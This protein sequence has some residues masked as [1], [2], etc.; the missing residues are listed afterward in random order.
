MSET[1]RRAVPHIREFLADSLTPLG[2]YRRLAELS[3]HRF[4]LESV[5]GGERVSRF[6]FLGAGPREVYRLYPDRLEVER[7]G[8]RSRLPGLPLDALREVIHRIHSEPGPIPFTGGLVG[9][10]GYDLIRMVERLPNR[11]ADPFGL[12]IAMLARFDTLVIFDHAYQR[13]LAIANEIEGEVNMATA[14]RQLARIS[15][16]LTNEAGGGGV[17]MPE[18][19]P[20]RAAA[21]PSLD[22]PAFRKAVLAAKEHIAA[23]DIFQVV[24][25][26]RWTVPRRVDPLALYRAVRMVNPSPYMVL[27]ESPD[28]SLVGASP[29]MLVRKQG[30]HLENRPI[31]GTRPRGM[32]AEGDKRLAEDLLADAK[33]RAEHVML[34][35]LGRNDLGR[36]ATA[37]SVR[38]ASFME[39]ERYS[40]VMHMV[41]SVEAELEAGKDGLDALLACFPAGTVSG[42]PKIRAME[43]IDELEPE[44]RGPYAGAVGYLSYSG[45]LDTCIAIRTLVVEE[46]RTSVTAGAGIVA[47]SDP[48]A[49][50]KETENKAAALLAAVA[51]AEAL[52]GRRS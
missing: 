40:H 1:P 7:G 6:S 9:Y 4:L 24:L 36:V 19:S 39:I 45:D 43:I 33:E 27:F 22:G 20:G 8:K 13:V 15:K 52:E 23:G 51:L 35:D 42:A 17:A 11:P 3:P 50:E 12:P 44:A 49:E 41:S 16:L 21:T 34:V 38:V 32:D 5:T 18:Q 26:R 29:E 25:A 10:F 30:R 28:V 2:V 37:G 47:D 31:A 46:G 48:A 14:E